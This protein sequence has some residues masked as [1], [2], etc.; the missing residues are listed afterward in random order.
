MPSL[1]PLQPDLNPRGSGAAVDHNA[2]AGSWPFRFLGEAGQPAAVGEEL[3]A[4]GILSAWVSPLD[5]LFNAEPYTANEWLIGEAASSELL[6][7][8]PVFNPRLNRAAEELRNLL[9]RHP[10]IPAI[11]LAPGYH[12]YE[13]D[14]Q[15]A[16]SFI[17]EA[18]SAKPILITVRVQ[19]R[20]GQLSLF[21]VADV[22]LASCFAIAEAF[23][24]RSFLLCGIRLGELSSAREKW[25][26]HPNL[27]IETSF[28]DNI[29][30]L[31]QFLE[32]VGENRLHLGTLA[33]LLYA[34]ASVEK[35]RK[36][37]LAEECMRKILTTRL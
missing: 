34:S 5:A 33:P 3:R 17:D 28:I 23:P 2:F 1:R 36:S 32:I 35:I 31:S 18:P 27:H 19:D 4:A 12:G 6:Q 13:L 10:E 26:Q 25:K 14:G 15:E 20:R 22:E 24:G 9:E 8:V 7:S 30:G 16:R 11:R 29:S 21:P 37:G